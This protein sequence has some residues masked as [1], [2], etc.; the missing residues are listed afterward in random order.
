MST[1]R[2]AATLISCAVLAGC[3]SS[4]S[5]APVAPSAMAS[6]L[7]A[8][9]VVTANDMLFYL[10]SHFTATPGADSTTCVYHRADGSEN[11][12]LVVAGDLGGGAS[13][14]LRGMGYPAPDLAVAGIDEA[15][16]SG[17]GH[18]VA[19]RSGGLVVWVSYANTSGAP[20]QCALQSVSWSL[21]RAALGVV[22]GKPH[23]SPFPTN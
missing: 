6:A 13:S 14:R 19:A 22:G 17:D 18:A 8:C 7:A 1:S 16:C 9:S 20:S 3:G 5:P 2:L 11:A 4:A 10:G 12:T 23:P 21:A 15:A